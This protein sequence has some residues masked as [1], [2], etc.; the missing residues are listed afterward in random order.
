VVGQRSMD[1]ILTESGEEVGAETRLLLQQILDDYRTGIQ[2]L[3]VALQT[4]RPPDEVRD[5]YDDMARARV[6]KERRINEALAYE[7][8][9]IPAVVVQA[10]QTIQEAEVSKAVRIIQAEEETDR[11]VSILCAYDQEEDATFRGL[12]LESL[13]SILPGITEFIEAV[14]STSNS[15]QGIRPRGH[16]LS[17]RRV[18][19]TP[20][21][22]VVLTRYSEGAGSVDAPAVTARLP[23][24]NSGAPLDDRLLLIDLS[25][26]TLLTLELR[27]LIVDAYVRYRITDPEQFLATLG[28]ESTA[29]SRVGNIVNAAIRAEVAL[30]TQEDVIGGNTIV[31]DDGSII[32]QP[33]MM[34]N[35]TP[36]RAAMMQLVVQGANQKVRASENEFGIEIVDVRLQRI[37]FPPDIEQSIFDRMRAERAFHAARL[38]AEG[39]EVYLTITADVDKQVAIILAEAER[40]ANILLDEGESAAIDIFIEALAQEPELS[41]YQRGLEAYK[42]SKG[43]ITS[44]FLPIVPNAPRPEIR[45]T[46]RAVL[47]CSVVLI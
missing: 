11:F 3:D 6:D 10:A 2:V 25:P 14:Q 15:A 33:R 38:R 20:M 32:V 13:E 24:F 9:Q 23:F 44:K 19:L 40:D 17:S 22:R 34:A 5:A 30:R 1:D 26:D 46:P 39:E 21:Q 28:T 4:A 29:H 27:R 7:R 35:G 12:H 41:R 8:D 43:M 18:T 31:L 45:T 47:T 42:V 16:L 36:T 37:S